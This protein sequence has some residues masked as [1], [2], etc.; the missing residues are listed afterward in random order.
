IAGAAAPVKG[1]A[2]DELLDPSSTLRVSATSSWNGL[3][4]YRVANLFD[5]R[6]NTAWIARSPSPPLLDTTSWPG[7]RALGHAASSSQ[8]GSAPATVDPNPVIHLRWDGVRTLSSLSVAA[9]G[10]FAVAP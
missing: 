9:A 10:G 2:L 5:G 1:G 3:P 7:A 4:E 6:R 8:V